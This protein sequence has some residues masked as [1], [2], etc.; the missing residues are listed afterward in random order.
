MESAQIVTSFAST[1]CSSLY[2]RTRERPSSQS[3]PSRAACRPGRLCTAPMDSLSLLQ[4]RPMARH[5]TVP[6]HRL[7][8]SITI[9]WPLRP[10]STRRRTTGQTTAEGD[11]AR[12]T[13][14][15]ACR[16]RSLT[17][18]R[19]TPDADRPPRRRVEAR[20]LPPTISTRRRVTTTKGCLLPSATAPE[21]LPRSLPP[22]P[23]PNLLTETP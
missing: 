6:R 14:A 11:R 20:R 18:K 2:P 19:R 21:G 12:T 7:P 8:P 22:P 17:S 1:A 4:E 23:P 9:P 5:H 10:I 15:C 3:R 13:Q 16:L